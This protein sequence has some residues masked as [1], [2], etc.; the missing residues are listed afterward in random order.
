VLRQQAARFVAVGAFTA[1][2]DFGAYRLLLAVDVPLTPAKA[3]GFVLGTT[4]S[5]L[6]NRAWTFGAGQHAVRR[7]VA[8]YT[9]TLVLNVATNAAAHAA[10]ADL[11]GR[12]TVAWLLAQAVASAANFWGM[13]HYVF[14]PTPTPSPKEQPRE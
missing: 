14:P 6:L 3:A 10:L 2:L 8:L 13:R 4:A 12:V 1:L 5:Y 11:P 7:F 9:V